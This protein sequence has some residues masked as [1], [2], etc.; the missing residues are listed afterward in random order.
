[1]D[2]LEKMLGLLD[3]ALRDP[4]SRKESVEEFLNCFFKNERDVKRSIGQNAVDVLD[5][6][7]YDLGF[8]VADPAVRAEDPSYYGDERLVVE[9]KAALR[10]LSHVG[11]ATPDS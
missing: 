5:E 6:L 2:T 9:I 7:A 3:K 8:F 11:V 10:R 4:S 1:M